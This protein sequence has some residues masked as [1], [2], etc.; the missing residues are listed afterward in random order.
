MIVLESNKTF[1][2]KGYKVK[3][4]DDMYIIYT[5]DGV[6]D[7]ECETEKLARDWIDNKEPDPNDYS[8]KFEILKINSEETVK[9]VKQTVLDSYYFDTRKFYDIGWQLG[10]KTYNA[11]KSALAKLRKFGFDI[12]DNDIEGTQRYPYRAIVAV[13]V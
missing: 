8:D 2:Y 3:Y 12:V 6:E 1:V 5:P 7:W 11:R 13:K 4:K 9:Q 10:Y